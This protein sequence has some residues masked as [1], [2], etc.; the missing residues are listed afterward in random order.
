MI[1]SV[2]DREADLYVLFHEATQDPS[3]PKLLIRA[4]RTRRR[5]VTDGNKEDKNED[6]WKKMEGEPVAGLINVAIPRRGSMSARTAKLQVRFAQVLIKPPTTSK[7]TSPL[8]IWV[9]H[10]KEIDYSLD[11]KEPIDW[12]LLT[13]INTESFEDACERLN[14]YARRWGIEVYHRTIK[15]GCRIQDRRLDDAQSIETCLAIDLVVAW[16]V[17]WLTMVGR[18]NPESPC[19]QIL[20]EDEWRVLSAWAT[21]KMADAPPSAQKAMHWIGK[22]GGWLCRGKKDNPG[23][24]CIWRGMTRLPNIVQGYRLALETYGIR[25]GP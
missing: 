7:L 2:G 25:A 12:M 1:V 24:T 5:K 6:L 14:W 18:E 20:S 23:T 15:S 22:L 10:T 9:V 21:G 3:G 17:Y 8:S 13:T 11:V 16:R 4:E 19:D